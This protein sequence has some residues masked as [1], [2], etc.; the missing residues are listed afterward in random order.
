MSLRSF[1]VCSIGVMPRASSAAWMEA[2]VWPQEHI[3][4]MRLEIWGASNTGLPRSIPSKNLGDSM[5]SRRHCSSRPSLTFTTMFPCPSTRFRYSTF[6]DISLC[7]L[8]LLHA[9]IVHPHLVH[10]LIEGDVVPGKDILHPFLIGVAH[11]PS[12][13]I[14]DVPVVHAP[15]V[16]TTPGN[17]AQAAYPFFIHADVLVLPAF[18]AYSVVRDKVRDPLEGRLQHLLEFGEIYGTAVDEVVYLDHL[19]YWLCLLG[20]EE[21]ATGTIDIFPD[22]PQVKT[23]LNP[24]APADGGAGAIS[25]Q[26]LAPLPDLLY[27][28]RSVGVCDAPFHYGYV[29][30][31]L[32]LLGHDLPELHHVYDAQKVKEFLPQ[33]C[34]LELAPLAA[35]K[36]KKGH[37]WFLH[38]T[39]PL[40]YALYHCN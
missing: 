22:L 4:H 1:I 21:M 8:F 3:P 38:I 10:Y 36:I 40:L 39:L 20:G 37:L 27:P 19:L 24:V 28:L 34:H 6:I 12:A 9:L 15:G 11:H 2:R 35:G 30:V 14:A 29:E 17:R 18:H 13:P 16:A 33:V 23:V 32:P 31:P 7:I 25:Y 5:M 26:C